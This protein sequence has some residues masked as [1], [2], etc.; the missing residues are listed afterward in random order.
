MD[1]LFRSS[2]VKWLKTFDAIYPPISRRADLLYWN[3]R[4][5][6]RLGKEFNAQ[7]IVVDRTRS[8]RVVKFK[9]IYP[10]LLNESAVFE[11]YELPRAPRGESAP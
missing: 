2:I 9:R 8:Q 3:D 4:S 10:R 7:Y 5:L 11:V 1:E 6:E